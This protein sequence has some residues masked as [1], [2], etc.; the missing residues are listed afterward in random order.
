L[1]APDLTTTQHRTG[2]TLQ[3]ALFATAIAWSVSSSLLSASSARGIT[4]RFDIDSAHPLLAS[5]FFLFLLAVGFSLLQ[6][7][8][9]RPA[10]ARSVLGLP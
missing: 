5:L 6:T 2:K 4:N 1:S 3:L 10:T 7:I 8:V 9:R